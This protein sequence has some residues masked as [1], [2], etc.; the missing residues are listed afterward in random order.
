[1]RSSP[2]Q[3]SGDG[4]RGEVP[5]LTALRGIAALLVCAMHLAGSF[6][7]LGVSGIQLLDRAWLAVELFLLMSGF[8]DAVMGLG[9]R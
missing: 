7:G 2:Q 9:R 5:G 3:A 4:G 8:I 6:P 1:M